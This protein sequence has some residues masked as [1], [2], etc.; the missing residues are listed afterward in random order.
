MT[1]ISGIA[2]LFKTKV[3]RVPNQG[4]VGSINGPGI[5]PKQLLGLRAPGN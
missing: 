1:L 2:S 5:A 3:E 4:N